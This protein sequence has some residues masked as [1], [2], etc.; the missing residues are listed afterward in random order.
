M[1]D[2]ARQLLDEL[3]GLPADER[4]GVVAELLA[5]AAPDVDGAQAAEISRRIREL[6][7]GEGR[8]RSADAVF[9][10]LEARASRQ[11]A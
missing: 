6:R 5:L 2:R 11:S 8:G 9:D 4:D 7:A 3:L 10:E 1:T